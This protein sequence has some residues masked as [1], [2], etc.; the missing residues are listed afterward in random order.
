M[1]FTVL[2]N[3]SQIITNVY[4]L[5]AP[6]CTNYIHNF[7]MHH[8][9][10]WWRRGLYSRP[11]YTYVYTQEHVCDHTP[12]ANAK[13]INMLHVPT[14]TK[15]Q[16]SKILFNITLLALICSR[17]IR[18]EAFIHALLSRAYLC[19]SWAFLLLATAQL[20][21]DPERCYSPRHMVPRIVRV[22]R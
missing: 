22:Q 14:K 15:M 9:L 8:L 16:P 21:S 20:H 12:T 3:F 13:L 11:I 5:Y 6:E 10:S 2:N 19:V 17:F 18:Y 1:A 7:T 4:P